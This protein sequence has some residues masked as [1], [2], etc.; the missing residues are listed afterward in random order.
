MH[1]VDNKA[2]QMPWLIL[3]AR[4]LRYENN[5]SMDPTNSHIPPKNIIKKIRGLNMNTSFWAYVPDKST[6]RLLKVPSCAV[7]QGA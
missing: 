4:A 5:M 1:V 7:Y 6:L 3:A 2:E